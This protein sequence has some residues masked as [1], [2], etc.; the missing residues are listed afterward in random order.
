[1]AVLPKRLAGYRANGRLL[2]G[3]P[4]TTE[5]HPEER[6]TLQ[7]IGAVISLFVI[8]AWSIVVFLIHAYS[9]LSG[10][11]LELAFIG[12]V[13][14]VSLLSIPFYLKRVRWSYL[15]GILVTILLVVGAVAIA[16][17]RAIFFYP[18]V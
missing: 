10:D 3:D 16:L 15:G 6:W 12:T 9:P 14:V 13:A 7:Q 5:T 18:S 1:L 4:I 11:T 2:Q 17:E 8:C